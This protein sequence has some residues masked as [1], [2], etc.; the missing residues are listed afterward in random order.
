MKRASNYVKMYILLGD[1]TGTVFEPVHPEH[2]IRVK[3][4]EAPSMARVGDFVELNATIENNGQNDESNINV[5]FSI[6]D[7]VQDRRVISSLFAGAEEKQGFS[8]TVTEDMNPL[9]IEVRASSVP[10][11]D[12]LSD[13]VKQASIDIPP[14]LFTDI[15]SASGTMDGIM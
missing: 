14:A 9:E 3:S 15:Y 13:N 8:F 10:G 6:N 11:E 4:I 1:P 2:N 12:F 5:N 7:V